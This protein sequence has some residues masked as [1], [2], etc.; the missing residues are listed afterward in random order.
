MN[1]A[2]VFGAGGWLGE[3]L[4]ERLTGAGREVICVDVRLG[5]R[6]RQLSGVEAIEADI[7]D[8]TALSARFAEC[9]TVFNCA[10]VL[11]PKATRDIYAINATAAVSLFGECMRGGV[12]SFVHI[13]SINALGPNQ[14]ST[15]FLDE[16]APLHPI[17]HYGRSKAQGEQQLKALVQ[18][19]NTRLIMLRPAVFYG[20]NPSKNLRE[21]I[22]RIGESSVP[23]F[24]QRG[25]LR[26][27][28]DIAK[29]V[30]A[31]I[32]AET[33][34]VSGEAYL[35]GD[36][37]PM[38]T[39]RFYQCLAGA[40]GT[41]LKTTRV[42]AAVARLSEKIAMWAGNAGIH[43]RLPTIVGEFGRHTYYSFEKAKREL[44]FVPHASSEP[45]I[46]SMVRSTQQ[47]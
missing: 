29:V 25:F 8:V 18:P 30:D 39:L 12:G 42:P 14:T 22:Q 37:E 47:S 13:S 9:E 23:V 10:G 27:Y 43:L 11:H 28:V 40:L 7:R 24:S 26:S 6:I 33:N 36:E 15:V 16:T 35:I 44:G 34:G 3:R 46:R 41:P 20:D 19:G 21:L 31:M 17:T 45:G 38:S 4:I 1:K 2:M 5:S 32:L